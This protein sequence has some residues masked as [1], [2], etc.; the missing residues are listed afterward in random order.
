MGGFPRSLWREGK[1]KLAPIYWPSAAKQMIGPSR[2]ESA[3]NPTAALAAWEAA[4]PPRVNVD[5]ARG[6]ALNP[7][8]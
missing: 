3:A 5:R 6:N 2:L 4:K 1:K 8:P 7:K